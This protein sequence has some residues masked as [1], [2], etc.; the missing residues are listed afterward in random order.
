MITRQFRTIDA[1]A[2]S[3]LIIADLKQ[4]NSKFYPED[5]IKRMINL[6]TPRRIIQTAQS[7]LVLVA[8][9]FDEIVGTATISHNFFGSVFTR[10][11]LHGKGVGTKLMDTLERLTKQNGMTEVKLHASINAVKF[12]EKRGFEI[13]GTVNDVKFGESYEMVKE[14]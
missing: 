3:A 2:V 11:D 8:E 14:L 4:I 9:M 6:Y 1:S 10:P 7:Q 13:I 5:V 12:Y